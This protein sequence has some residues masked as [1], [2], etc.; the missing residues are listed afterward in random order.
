M[1]SPIDASSYR[2]IGRGYDT[3]I[4]DSLDVSFQPQVKVKL[5]DNESNFSMRLLNFG[6]GS[7]N[8][9]GSRVQ[10]AGNN[11][12]CEFINSGDGF[13]F[14][15]DLISK[16]ATNQLR[17]S[18]ETKNIVVFKQPE[19]TPEEIA[20]GAF[21]PDN[22]INSYAVYHSAKNNNEYQ[23]GKILHLYRP[24][25]TDA[26]SNSVWCDQ[27]INVPVR[28]KVITIPQSFLDTA[29]YPVRIS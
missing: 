16:P 26:N 13:E 8:F 21:R 20:D 15:I 2:H 10:W 14:Y 12:S 23:T 29:V 27:D 22:V 25:A 6:V 4:G 9:D 1:I 18:L 28:T 5:W 24:K 11:A 19:L 3:E 17:F 7:H